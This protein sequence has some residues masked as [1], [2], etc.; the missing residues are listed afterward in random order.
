MM[1]LPNYIPII[2]L[3]L[4]AIKQL[5]LRLK[6]RSPH[7]RVIFVLWLI[8]IVWAVVW[9][10]QDLWGWFLFSKA[11]SR[12]LLL[13]LCFLSRLAMGMDA[14]SAM[15]P[16]FASTAGSMGFQVSCRASSQSILQKIGTLL[17]AWSRCP[18]ITT[19]AIP[20]R[21]ILTHTSAFRRISRGCSRGQMRR[22]HRCFLAMM[23]RL[24]LSRSLPF[25]LLF[26]GH[27]LFLPILLIFSTVAVI[28][29]VALM[30]LI[31]VRRRCD[32]LLGRL[33]THGSFLRLFLRCWNYLFRVVFYLIMD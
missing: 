29:L 28:Q 32:F 20:I 26:G 19:I 3:L 9:D 4:I 22:R 8:V 13:L 12:L 15:L 27:P 31:I 24:L 30:S 21:L 14:G 1:P 11:A 18:C 10:N 7:H 33:L 23:P 6:R 2:I 5:W 17:W 16:I 25:L